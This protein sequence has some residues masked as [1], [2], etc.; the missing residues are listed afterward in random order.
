MD[1]LQLPREVLLLVALFA[2]VGAVCLFLFL[3][4]M[5]SEKIITINCAGVG[6]EVQLL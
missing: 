4:G 2:Y 5:V 1:L 6:F 3:V